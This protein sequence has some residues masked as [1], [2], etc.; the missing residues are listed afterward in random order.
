MTSKK[1]RCDICGVGKGRHRTRGQRI[2]TDCFVSLKPSVGTGEIIETFVITDEAID[3]LL[4]QFGTPY[5]TMTQPGS[6]N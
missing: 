2:C 4:D 3:S 6:R 1:R 5:P